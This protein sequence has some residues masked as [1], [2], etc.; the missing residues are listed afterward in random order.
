MV[1]FTNPLPLHLLTRLNGHGIGLKRLRF[2]LAVV[3]E[4]VWITLRKERGRKPRI[5]LAKGFSSGRMD[6]RATR[7]P[8]QLQLFDPGLGF[9]SE[10][11]FRMQRFHCIGLVRVVLPRQAVPCEKCLQFF[12]R[13]R[14]RRLHC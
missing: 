9:L 6:F 13:V 4:M 1:T 3:S 11:S 12:H 5:L 8:V 10:A 2:K 7:W 14:R